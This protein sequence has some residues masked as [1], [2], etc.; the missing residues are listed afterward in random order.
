MWYFHDVAGHGVSCL[1]PRRELCSSIAQEAHSSSFQLLQ[2]YSR[3][4]FQCIRTQRPSSSNQP[5][6][7]LSYPFLSS[8]LLRWLVTLIYIQVKLRQEL[9]P[10]AYILNIHQNKIVIYCSNFTIN[11]FLNKSHRVSEHHHNEPLMKPHPATSSALTRAFSGCITQQTD[12]FIT[13]LNI[14]FCL[15]IF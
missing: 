8:F 11:V 4:V 5:V 7:T 12:P 1:I 15:F 13:A 9:E 6:L 3:H 10:Q 2:Y 14:S